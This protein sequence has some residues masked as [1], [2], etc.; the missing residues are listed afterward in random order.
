VREYTFLA[1]RPGGYMNWPGK[2]VAGSA[3]PRVVAVLLFRRWFGR[4]PTSSWSWDGHMAQAEDERGNLIEI[5]QVNWYS[6]Y[7]QGATQMSSPLCP[8]IV[9]KEAA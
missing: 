5:T 1:R 2:Y 8:M 9:R 7:H 3:R 6:R 4:E